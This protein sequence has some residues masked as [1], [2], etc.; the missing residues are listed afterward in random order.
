MTL[1]GTQETEAARVNRAYYETAYPG[2]DDYWRFMAAPRAR[3][4][5]LLALI[6]EESVGSVIDLG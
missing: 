4:A 3:A 6:Q 1:R 2:Q 5:M